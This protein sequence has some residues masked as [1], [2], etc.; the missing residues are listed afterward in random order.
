M[1]NVLE[2]YLQ[3]SLVHQNDWQNTPP[4]F[5][6]NTH[7]SVE[8]PACGV[9]VFRPVVAVASTKHIVLSSGVHGN[10][11]APIEICNDL[12]NQIGTGDLR[13]SHNVMFIFGNLPAIA[14]QTRFIEDNLNRLFTPNLEGEGLEIARARVI[15]AKINEFYANAQGERIHYDLHTAIRPSKNEKFAVYPYLH[16]K[17][18]K[19]QQLQFMSDCGVNTILLSQTTTTT[20]SYFSSRYHQ[21][22]AFT[23]ELGQ[24]KPFG[25]NDMSKFADASRMLTKLISN[26]TLELTPFADCPLQI[27]TVNQVINKNKD[28][29]KLHFADDLSNFSDFN[30]GDILASE[31]GMEYKAQQTGEAIVFPN[32]KVEIGQRALLTVV[33]C[34]L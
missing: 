15:M 30:K 2:D 19:K 29:F 26:E 18:H 21:A 34:E 22:D 5:E 10:E 11:T 27:Y 3:Y 31:S 7:T 4:N 13:L 16:G 9:V 6:I 1:R 25:E 17:A 33:P 32:A 24:V 14:K 28:D 20:F 23:V 8:L 12:I